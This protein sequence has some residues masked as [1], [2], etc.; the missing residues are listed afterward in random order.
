MYKTP[1]ILWFVLFWGQICAGQ[2]E[3]IIRRDTNFLPFKI[4]FENDTLYTIYDV[5][6]LDHKGSYTNLF[7]IDDLKMVD[8]DL[9]LNYQ[10]ESME[11]SFN[12]YVNHLLFTI[13]KD[14]IPIAPY[15][16]EGNRI[17][18]EPTKE[19]TLKVSWQD[20]SESNLYSGR[21]YQLVTYT[22]LYGV[23]LD[24]D[25]PPKF[26]FS[27]WFPH[28]GAALA[29]GG[30]FYIGEKLREDSGDLYG[31]YELSWA[32]EA[33]K[34]TGEANYQRYEGKRNEHR[35]YTITGWSVLGLNAIWLSFRLSNHKKRKKVYQTYCNPKVIVSPNVGGI[36][37]GN[38]FYGLRLNY[39][40][41]H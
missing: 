20:V 18:V 39:S 1:L 38:E 32:N 9:N 10:L 27:K 36:S 24:C 11:E 29:S 33:I 3:T 25:D 6:S 4:G 15:R 17:R 21:D 19:E 35:A 2:I 28:L 37:T 30:L 23:G 26:G 16:M 34:E 8:G 5:D 12:Y 14:S 31:E 22:Q 40:I 13:N 41:S 7:K